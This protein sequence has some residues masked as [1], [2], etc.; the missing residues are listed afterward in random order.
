[1]TKPVSNSKE[2]GEVVVPVAKPDAD[3]LLVEG[4]DV[5]DGPNLLRGRLRV[6]VKGLLQGRA[7]RVVDRRPLLATLADQFRARRARCRQRLGAGT[8]AVD[9]VQ[10][11]LEQ[12]L[13]LAHVFE[14]QVEGFEPRDGRLREVVAVHLPHRRANVALRVTC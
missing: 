10:P 2:I 12:R 8:R 14:R 13:E 3:D 4:E 7:N 5:A 6:L 9:L 11:P 1:M